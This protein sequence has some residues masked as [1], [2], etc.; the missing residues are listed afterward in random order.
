MESRI[1]ELQDSISKFKKAL[2]RVQKEEAAAKS[3]AEKASGEIDRWKE[4][5]QGMKWDHI[6]FQEIKF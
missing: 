5:I 3:A 6:V 2:E 1:N 4:E